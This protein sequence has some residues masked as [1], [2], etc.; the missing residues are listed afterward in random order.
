[1]K[2][3]KYFLIA[4]FSLTLATSCTEDDNDALTG[5][6]NEGGVIKTNNLLV[7]YVVGEQGPYEASFTITQGNVT[8]AN[9]DIYKRF[10]SADGSASED[11]FFKTIDISTTTPGATVTESFSFTY[12]DLA[13]G[14]T[15]NGASLPA[16]DT[17][18]TIG[19][20]F[21]LTYRSNLSNGDVHRLPN[22]GSYNTKVAVGTRLAGT[23]TIQQ[24]WY[25]HPSTA[26]G[27]AGD[28]SGAYDRV[29]ESVALTDDYTVYKSTT[30]GWGPAGGWDDPECN[31]FYF[32][33]SNTPEAD[34]VTY[35]I[36]IPETY[37]GVKQ[38]LWCSDDI[39]TCSRTPGNIPDTSCTMKA[40]FNA[41]GHDEI[42]ISYGY[43]RSSG[44]RQFDEILIKQ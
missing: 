17:G 38:T 9:V 30:M 42:Y 10:V 28:Y 31:F 4:L 24:G 18:L 37:E 5:N 23:Y 12:S 35:A 1:M 21:I 41:D 34:G 33:V 20:A 36:T 15:F 11:V 3:I 8:T 39:A 43:I 27:L 14:I 2:T 19:D 40:V 29:I 6:R 16:S 44:T 7:P 22:T 26:P 32:N 13:E 25:I